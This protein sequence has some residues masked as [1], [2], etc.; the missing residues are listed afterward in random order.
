MGPEREQ[1]IN[2]IRSRSAKDGRFEGSTRV[3]FFFQYAPGLPFPHAAEEAA[4]ET[5]E[6]RLRYL[7]FSVLLSGYHHV[8]AYHSN[9]LLAY[10]YEE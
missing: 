10:C 5:A 9:P 3:D 1:D 8:C 6:E 2:K 7:H 4:E